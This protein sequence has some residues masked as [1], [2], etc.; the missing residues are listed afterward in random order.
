M[1][2]KET[3]ANF[4]SILSSIHFA[5]LPA[6]VAELADALDSGSSGGNP[7]EVQVLSSAL[8]TITNKNTV[9]STI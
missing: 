3:R 9:D 2:L 6:D 5:F 7:V 8:L 4:L 1:L